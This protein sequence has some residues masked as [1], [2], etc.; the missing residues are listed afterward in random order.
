MDY[1]W[2][3]HGLSEY[4]EM[5]KAPDVSSRSGPDRFRTSPL[6]RLGPNLK[7]DDLPDMTTLYGRRMSKVL[8]YNY[9]RYLTDWIF[10]QP[11]MSEAYSRR[12]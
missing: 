4:R 12:Q 7:K 6:L 1:L 2:V 8:A 11:G 10:G 9:C 5:L 3:L